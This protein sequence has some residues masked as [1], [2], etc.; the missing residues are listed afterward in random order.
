MFLPPPSSHGTPS[1]PVATQPDS[2]KVPR[3]RAALA[4]PPSRHPALC[5]ARGL[6]WP[7]HCPPRGPPLF[8]A[9][10]PAGGSTEHQAASLRAE[11]R[12]SFRRLF[13]HTSHLIP[14]VLCE[15]GGGVMK[16]SL[17]TGEPKAQR[18]QGTGLGSTA[19]ND[20]AQS[21]CYLLSEKLF[22]GACF[23]QSF[24]AATGPGSFPPA[25]RSD[26]PQPRQP[27]FSEPPVPR[28]ETA[29][30]PELGSRPVSV[31]HPPVL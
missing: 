29:R 15:A 19:G 7:G 17:C 20:T 30:G 11:S 13:R 10:L 3:S 6:S 28:Q 22:T 2:A 27:H 4:A 26:S 14:S 21:P 24:P 9:S 18:R 5:L 1:R 23:H 16:I 31:C 12:Q 25:P 8:L